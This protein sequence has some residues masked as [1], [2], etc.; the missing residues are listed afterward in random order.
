MPDWADVVRIGG[1]LPGVEE[2]TWYRTPALKVRGKG[3]V[4]LRTEAEGLL[5]VM[6]GLDEKAA[7]LASGDPAFS[8]TPHYDGHG[9]ILVDLGAVDGTQL[10]ELVEEAWRLRAPAALRSTPRG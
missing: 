4:R 1:A 10:A 9:A 7:L 2:S 8:T 3:F 5:V 6:C